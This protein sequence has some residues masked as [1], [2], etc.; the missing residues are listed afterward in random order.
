MTAMGVQILSRFLMIISLVFV[1]YETV[2]YSSFKLGTILFLQ[3]LLSAGIS[4]GS[5]R[6]WPFLFSFLS[7]FFF[8]FFFEVSPTYPR[9]TLNVWSFISQTEITDKGCHHAQFYVVLGLK[10]RN[11]CTLWVYYSSFWKILCFSHPPPLK[12]CFRSKLY[13]HYLI[14][15]K[16]QGKW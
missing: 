14:L 13:S 1:I 10:S 12:N 3:L 16:E 9:M 6:I 8:F 7:F 15:R 5:H 11:L 4:C 2:S